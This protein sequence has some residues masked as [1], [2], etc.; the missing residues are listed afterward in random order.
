MGP[1]VNAPADDQ[2]EQVELPYTL[3]LAPSGSSGYLGEPSDS[4]DGQTTDHLPPWVV[5]IADDDPGVHQATL[6]ALTGES[7]HGRPLAFLHAASAAEA[8][9][10]LRARMDV[11]VV[12][13]DVV[14]ESPAAGLDLIP[15]IR[16]LPGHAETR[17]ILRTGQP[18]QMAE[19]ELR[20]QFAIDGYLTKGQQTR[21]LLLAALHRALPQVVDPGDPAEP[22]AH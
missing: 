12:L 17:I 6:I 2:H 4:E 21:A 22:P 18:G 5:L 3:W 11:A 16:A 9:A 19:G 10:L 14:M 20:T 15:E 1:A 8:A 7:V 13:L